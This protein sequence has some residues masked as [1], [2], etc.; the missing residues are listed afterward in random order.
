MRRST[1]CLMAMLLLALLPLSRPAQANCQFSGR[2]GTARVEFTT[3]SQI[4]VP[5]NVT[6]GTVLWRSPMTPQNANVDVSCNKR[7]DGG[8]TSSIGI[9]PAPGATTF[10]T[11]IPGLSIRLARGSTA[12]YLMAKSTDY[13]TSG[14]TTFSQNTSLELVTSD[15][16]AI[17]NGSTLYAGQ[18]AHWDFGNLSSVVVFQTLN[19]ITF[20]RPCTI[21]VEPTVVTLRTV[22]ASELQ[23]N[24]GTTAGDTPFAIKLSCPAALPLKITLD[25]TNPFNVNNGVLNT[26]SGSGAA[27]GVGVQ[28]LRGGQPL[29]LRQ[30]IDV[31]TSSG[32]VDIPFSARYYRTGGALQPGSVAATATYTLTYP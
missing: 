7:T 21:S 6:P 19:T 22:T 2:T 24:S 9:Q 32:P 29:T 3:P 23:G 1:Q 16:V 28:I 17:A 14:T 18:L 15:S 8:I 26:S 13:L 31:T 11:N 5:D 4:T 27:S 20:N 25:A 30:A 10:A 12:T